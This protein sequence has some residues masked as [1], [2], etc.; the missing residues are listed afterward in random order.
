[1]KAKLSSVMCPYCQ[2]GQMANVI[3]GSEWLLR[4]HDCL[5]EFQHPTIDVVQVIQLQEEPASSEPRQP[6]KDFTP[7][8]P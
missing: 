5:R 1:M 6:S 7:V 3:R 2:R 4:C 8:T